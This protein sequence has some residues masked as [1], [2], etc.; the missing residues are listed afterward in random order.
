MSFYNLTSVENFKNIISNVKPKNEI[1]TV[2]QYKINNNTKY[3]IVK[4]DKNFLCDDLIETIGLFRS[5]VLDENNNVLCFSPPKSVSSEKFIKKYNNK[6]NDIVAEEFVEGT[7]I[8]LFYD[9]NL[10]KWEISTRNTVSAN[11][12]FYKNTSNSN[13]NKTF[14]TMFCEAIQ[15]SEFDI[16][17]KC[18]KK[19]CYSFV[20][21]HPENR[22]VIPFKE[23]KLYLV[24]VYE[25]IKDEKNNDIVI[26][27]NNDVCD[28]VSNW[29]NNKI[30]TP[31][32]YKKWETYTD[33]IN[34]YCS[35]LTSYE[36]LGV[37]I[38]NI[39]TGERC[40]I[41]NP[42][43]CQVKELRGNQPKLQYNYLILRQSGKV[44]DFLNYYPEYNSDFSNYR[45]QI[46]LFTS[47][48]YKY[49]I[50]CFIK[51]EQKLQDCSK[52]YKLHIYNLHKIYIK[53]LKDK[54]LFINMQET[55]KYV[56]SLHPSL[57][58]FSLNY[59]LRK[60]YYDCN[61][62]NINIK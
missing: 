60:R 46:H 38:K 14:N 37:V 30:Y 56:N 6:T 19:Y 50:S 31:I 17:T 47:T 20:L 18:N 23:T 9:I 53:E 58:L 4:Y 35:N 57:L 21:Q 2:S 59:N 3:K 39:T 5:V 51:K 12:S 11:I 44:S 8:N 15:N 22:I 24:E 34:T 33:L 45:D 41:R 10:N 32:I 13:N 54:K 28:I 29:C 1:L 36:I 55:I 26:N 25:I 7:M 40:K 42:T 61:K 49:Y 16:E 43:Y 52:Q 48:L 62:D 27:Y